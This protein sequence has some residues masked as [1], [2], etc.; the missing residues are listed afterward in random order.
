MDFPI[1][2]CRR[3]FREKD[4]LGFSSW[5]VLQPLASLFCACLD[6][7]EGGKSGWDRGVVGWGSRDPVI[8][9]RLALMGSIDG[10]RRE[11]GSCVFGGNPSY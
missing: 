7:S 11:G 9:M 2:F 8:S 10:P 1:F 3:G 6:G 4:C 5:R